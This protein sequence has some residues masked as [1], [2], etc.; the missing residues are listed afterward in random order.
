MGR[1]P[2]LSRQAAPGRG[3]G[4]HEGRGWAVSGPFPVARSVFDVRLISGQ[5]ERDALFFVLLAGGSLLIC[6]RQTLVFEA[7]ARVIFTECACKT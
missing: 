3:R 7:G 6:L 1:G 2:D 4:G 5:A